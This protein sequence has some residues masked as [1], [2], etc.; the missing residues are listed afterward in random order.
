MERQTLG[1]LMHHSQHTLTSSRFFL[2]FP[3]PSLLAQY[4]THMARGIRRISKDLRRTMRGEENR[5]G[6]KLFLLSRFSSWFGAL[7]P[8]LSILQ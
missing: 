7:K 6:S 8:V 2:P 4:M 3:V 5:K 1:S